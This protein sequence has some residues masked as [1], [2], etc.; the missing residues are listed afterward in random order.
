MPLRIQR[1]FRDPRR[2]RVSY[3]AGKRGTSISKRYGRTTIN[4]RGIVTVRL[5][6][7]I[8]YRKR[9]P[10]LAFLVFLPELIRAV[11][12]V[13]TLPLR[14]I[15]WPVKMLARAITSRTQNTPALPALSSSR[16]E[17]PVASHRDAND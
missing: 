16:A 17:L 2:P 1:R 6:R 8:S 10:L 7:G 5:G 11:F 9:S 13:A 3:N 15:W 12:F 14:L 4:S